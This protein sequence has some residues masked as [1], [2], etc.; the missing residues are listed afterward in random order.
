MDLDA[1]HALN[2]NLQINW[3]IQLMELSAD[4]KLSPSVASLVSEVTKQTKTMA[5]AK[6]KKGS[7]IERAHYQYAFELLSEDD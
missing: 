6:R 1:S 5:K 3:I 7:N 4:E 2:R